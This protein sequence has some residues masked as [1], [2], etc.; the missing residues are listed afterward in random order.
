MVDVLY[1]IRNSYSYDDSLESHLNIM[2]NPKMEK[3]ND[4]SFELHVA[5]N[6]FFKFLDGVASR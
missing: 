3:P 2:L 5:S 1:K 6:I 4:N